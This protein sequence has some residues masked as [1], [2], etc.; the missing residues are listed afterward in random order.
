MGNLKVV[1]DTNIY[2]SAIFWK[3]IP[4]K[5]VRKAADNE[6]LAF[7]SNH[8]LNELQTVLARDFGRNKD[9]ISVIISSLN[10][11]LKLVES[12]VKVDLVKADPPDDRILECALACNAKYI[13]SQD[14]HLLK[15]KEYRDIRIIN[16]TEF[17]DLL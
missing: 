7:A 14:N 13:V 1:L 4:H 15:L 3:G 11:F 16:P 17:F 5:I 2:V 10:L 6:F 12:K 9:E 8:I